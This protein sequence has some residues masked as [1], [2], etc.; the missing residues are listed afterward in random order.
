MLPELKF[1]REQLE[2]IS[3][4]FI[5]L[6]KILFASSVVGFFIPA[7]QVEVTIPTFIIGAP[8][9]LIFLI[10]GVRVLR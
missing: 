10:I 6:S 8:L 7:A 3:K 1:N 2:S 9:S 5:D 4:Y